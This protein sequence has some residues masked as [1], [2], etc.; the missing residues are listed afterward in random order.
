MQLA[1]SEPS[2][3]FYL[4]IINAHH[5]DPRRPNESAEYGGR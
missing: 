3:S 1:G 2:L 5:R 4:P